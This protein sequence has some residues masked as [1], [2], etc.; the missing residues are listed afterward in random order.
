MLLERRFHSGSSGP[1]QA[2]WPLCHA[3]LRHAMPT[4]AEQEQ[5]QSTK[6]DRA[7]DK[8]GQPQAGD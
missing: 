7:L 6:P 5:P 3:A 8:K 2:S 1:A 4:P